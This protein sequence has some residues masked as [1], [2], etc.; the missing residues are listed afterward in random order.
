MN[1]KIIESL[2]KINAFINLSGKDI[3]LINFS[4]QQSIAFVKYIMA[5]I[6]IKRDLISYELNKVSSVHVVSNRSKE[7]FKMRDIKE[8]DS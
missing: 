5:N 1:S 4:I 2:S 6:F 3:S 7:S 8:R